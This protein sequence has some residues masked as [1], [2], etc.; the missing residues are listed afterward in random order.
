MNKSI[1]IHITE[2]CNLNCKY[3][4]HFSCIAE[5]EFYDLEMFESDISRLSYLLKG[6]LRD[7]ILIGENP[8]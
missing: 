4:A 6:E 2:H 8:Y 5:P 7:L 1:S 3:C